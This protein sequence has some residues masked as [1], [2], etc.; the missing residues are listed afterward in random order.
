MAT[1]AERAAEVR[2]DLQEYSEILPKVREDLDPKGT[3][4]KNQAVS[5]YQNRIHELEAELHELE[6]HQVYG[7]GNS[8]EFRSNSP[9]CRPPPGCMQNGA[10]L[11]G[12]II[13]DVF[14]GEAVDAAFRPV[15]QWYS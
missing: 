2:A 6:N 10:A 7:V 11:H 1:S 9:Q 4:S 14:S 12:G 13:V 15:V 5:F 3:E 8:E